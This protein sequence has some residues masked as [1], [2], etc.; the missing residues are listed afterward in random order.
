MNLSINVCMFLFLSL[1]HFSHPLSLGLSSCFSVCQLITTLPIKA[2]QSPLHLSPSLSPSLRMPTLC[3]YP[4][5]SVPSSP[6]SVSLSLSAHACLYPF[7][8]VP[9]SPLSVSLS[10][11]AHAHSLSLSLSLS[12]WLVFSP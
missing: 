3:L 1:P 2:S 8:S 11:S 4:F 6:L 12:P 7:P 10:L 5:P 9:S